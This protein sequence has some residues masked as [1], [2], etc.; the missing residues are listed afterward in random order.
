METPHTPPHGEYITAIETACQSLDPN[1]VEEL[2]ADVYR[3]LRQPHQLK[4]KLSRDKIEAMRQLK[5]HKDCMVLTAD[6]GVAL[7]VMERRDY[8]RKAKE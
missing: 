5:A 6:K 8:I 7:V 4:P 3:V 2:R 1:T